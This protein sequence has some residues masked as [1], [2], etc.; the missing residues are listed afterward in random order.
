MWFVILTRATA[1]FSK[2]HKKVL[3]K[4]DG[5]FSTNR[6][7]DEWHQPELHALW[8]GEIPQNCHIFASSLIPQNRC[9]LMTP[10]QSRPFQPISTGLKAFS[11]SRPRQVFLGKKWRHGNSLSRFVQRAVFFVTKLASERG[12]RI[13]F[14]SSISWGGPIGCLFL[15]RRIASWKFMIRDSREMFRFFPVH[16]VGVSTP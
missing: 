6:G 16:G 13:I 15:F 7:H 11:L 9:H 2:N 3:Q 10:D 5:I 8:S 1:C 4:L 12:S 14:Q